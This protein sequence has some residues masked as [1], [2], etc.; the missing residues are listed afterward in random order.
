MDNERH[1]ASGAEAIVYYADQGFRTVEFD[2]HGNELDA[3]IMENYLGDR[4]VIQRMGLLDWMA[5]EYHN[6][7]T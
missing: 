7:D 4:V 2:G 5:S 6:H 3:R 1:F